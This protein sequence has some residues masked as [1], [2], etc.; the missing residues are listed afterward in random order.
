[1]ADNFDSY[2][3]E[4]GN[5]T[6]ED[7]KRRQTRSN[8]G[9]A[10]AYGLF[11][12]AQR[13]VY[14]AEK[15]G[16]K[17]GI[18]GAKEAAEAQ[19]AKIAQR[20]ATYGQL[21]PGYTLAGSLASP[22]PLG[23]ASGALRLFSKAPPVIAAMGAGATTAPSAPIQPGPDYWGDVGTAATAGGVASGAGRVVGGI[24]S[25]KITPEA[26]EL[27]NKGVQLYPE[28]AVPPGVTHNLLKTARSFKAMFKPGVDDVAM[29]RSF[30][31][32]LANDILAPIKGTTTSTNKADLV[33]DVNEQVSKYYDN[34]FKNIGTALPTNQFVSEVNL[35]QQN[36]KTTMNAATQRKLDEI[37][38]NNII[39][40]F[41]IQTKTQGNAISGES[42][43][44]MNKYFKELEF[45]LKD[46]PYSADIDVSALHDAVKALRKNV[47][48]F[49]EAADPNGLIKIANRARAEQDVFE[50][51][52][53]ASAKKDPFSVADLESAIKAGSDQRMLAASKGKLQE[54]AAP[55]LAVMGEK[56][57]SPY[58][59]GRR[60]AM[61]G[62]MLT[63]STY[64]W[65]HNPI[66][67]T[68]AFTT[69]GVAPAIIER[70]VRSPS[71]RQ[72]V[73][74]ELIKKHGAGVVANAINQEGQRNAN[75]LRAEIDKYPDYTTPESNY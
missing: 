65:L 71:T 12:P 33:A 15:A 13:F 18:P 48:S 28:M 49:T 67:A 43:K 4:I 37:V 61:A 55:Y 20:E 24:L 32:A 51:A 1:M 17:L 5:D 16:E 50:R 69:L 73:L 2:W 7:Q 74:G 56:P 47:V 68:A 38:N 52:A 3:N 35:I 10:F 30:N 58:S 19:A 72:K 14:F 31:T 11:D 34:A 53:A 44:D 66:V 60:T 42:L 70:A 26:Q 9:L 54:K 40:R 59:V 23:I 45:K 29:N 25:P 39:R 46:A 36:A 27:I 22:I 57:I 8:E 6:A 75:Q 64:A 41:N 63:G 21:A 62:A